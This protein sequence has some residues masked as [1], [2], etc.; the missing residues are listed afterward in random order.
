MTKWLKHARLTIARVRAKPKHLH[1]W[2]PSMLD[3]EWRCYGCRKTVSMKQVLR[4]SG[5][6]EKLDLFWPMSEAHLQLMMDS[7][8]F[9]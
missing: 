8:V 6:K 1:V 5:S 9:R 3:D 7:G 4:A 2:T